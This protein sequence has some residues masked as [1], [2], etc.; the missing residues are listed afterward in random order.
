MDAIHPSPA[1]TDP[2][3]KHALLRK[4]AEKLEAS[5]LAEMLKSAG[6]G[7]SR[8]EF[9]GGAGEDQFTSFLVQEHAMAMVRAGG[10]G[11]SETIYNA[12]KEQER[13]G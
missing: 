8:Q 6:F 5:F 7:A 3:S 10:I 1:M 13:N 4:T 11:L 12:L 9:G 2:V